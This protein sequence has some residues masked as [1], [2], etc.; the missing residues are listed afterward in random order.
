MIGFS[1]LLSANSNHVKY[2]GTFLAAIG[3]YTNV[4]NCTAWNANNIGGS[5]KRAI[6]MALQVGIGNLVMT[7][8]RTFDVVSTDFCNLQGGIISAFMFLPQDAPHY[9]PGYGALIGFCAM[10]G[11][12]SVCMTAYL[13]FEN[14][15]RDRVGKTAEQY[16]AAEREAERHRGDH[17][18]FFR[19]SV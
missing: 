1:M 19:Y 2:A 6:G 8:I 4:P 11:L 12:L 5:T 3:I 10:A 17:A 16:T 9:R 18:S 13:R 15:R 14:R 7:I